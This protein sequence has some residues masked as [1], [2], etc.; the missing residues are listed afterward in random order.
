VEYT[1]YTKLSYFKQHDQKIA[2]SSSTRSTSITLIAPSKIYKS[3]IKILKQAKLLIIA[4]TI[5]D[6]HA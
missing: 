2:R 3:V 5:N 4:T 1:K 6:A